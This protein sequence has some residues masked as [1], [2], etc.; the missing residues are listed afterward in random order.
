MNKDIRISICFIDHPKVMKLERKLTFD[1]VKSLLRLWCFAAQN[2]PEGYLT[3][4]DEDDIEMAA[5]WPGTPGL[6]VSTIAG[7]SCKWLDFADGIY[8]LHDWEEHQGYVVHAKSRR[9]KA[10][11][12]AN[13]RW[14][15]TRYD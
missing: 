12:A 2:R 8:K 14:N 15:S 10:R 3:A 11:D 1:G 5:K 9:E 6:F 4:M 7:D 13:K